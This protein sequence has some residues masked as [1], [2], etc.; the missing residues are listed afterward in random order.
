[1]RLRR[2]REE[3]LASA[4]VRTGQRHSDCTTLVATR[5]QLIADRVAR[6]PVAIAAR[7]TVLGNEVR[8]DSVKLNVAVETAARE[9]NE[10]RNGEWRILPKKLEGDRA[11][12]GFDAGTERVSIERRGD[13][14]PHDAAIP[15]EVARAALD[16]TPAGE[17][18]DAKCFGADEWIVGRRKKRQGMANGI[19]DARAV[20]LPDRRDITD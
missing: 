15:V 8:D 12:G 3:I 19:G 1:M 20:A 16:A 10:V 7:V 4:G 2:K 6:T 14:I 11:T 9:R 18:R 5:V 17:R 13:D